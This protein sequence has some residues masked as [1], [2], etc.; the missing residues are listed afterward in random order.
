[1][2]AFILG[3]LGRT[4]ADAHAAALALGQ[5]YA[6]AAGAGLGVLAGLARAR[7]LA[8]R[9]GGTETVRRRFQASIAALLHC[10]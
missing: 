2:P 9:L 3:S 8:A 6:T 7:N 5:V 4:P 1:M 10:S